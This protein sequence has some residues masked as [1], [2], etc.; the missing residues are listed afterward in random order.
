M[1]R[2]TGPAAVRLLERPRPRLVLG[3]FQG[4]PNTVA[5]AARDLGLDLRVVHRDVAGLVAAG[6]VRV[7]REEPRA[8]RAVR[9]YRAV[10]D[11]FFV[12]FGA[13]RAPGPADL[14]ERGAARRDAAF[15]AA[16]ARAFADALAAQAGPRTWGWRVYFDGERA[17]VDEAYEDAEL[18]APLTG[19]QGPVGPFLTGSP[20]YRLTP[21]QARDVQVTL[22]RFLGRW[23]AWSGE[24]AAAG[25]GAPF[26]VRLGIAPSGEE[27]PT[28]RPS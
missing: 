13:T 12:P 6:L 10:S 21:E 4:R 27:D 18:R 24:N 14:D 5:R 19:W 7:E 15:R 3:A 11:A 1:Q 25:R 22:I 16:F 9:W 23:S 26:H 20:V 17:Q 28:T 8:G 2:V